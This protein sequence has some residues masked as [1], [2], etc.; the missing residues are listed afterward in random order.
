[1]KILILTSSYNMQL[2]FR[3]EFMEHLLEKNHQLDIYS[4][5]LVEHEI[6]PSKKHNLH[7]FSS[8][9]VCVLVDFLKIFKLIKLDHKIVFNYTVRN[10]FIS[11][12]LATLKLNKKK[13]IYFIAGLGRS[14]NQNSILSKFIVRIVAYA[15]GLND[16]RLV[17]MNNRDNEIFKDYCANPIK[18][19]SEGLNLN[20]FKFIKRIET[21]EK[22]RIVFLGRV[23]E[24]KG[25][26]DILKLAA[27]FSIYPNV[28]IDV[29]GDISETPMDFLDGVKTLANL[30]V[31]GFTKDPLSELINSDLVILPSR[32]NEGLPRIMLESFAIGR[33]CVAYNVP[34][35][36]DIYG[37]TDY[38][39]DF[40][41]DSCEELIQ[42][43]EKVYL[44]NEDS[45]NKTC[46]NLNHSVIMN[47]DLNVINKDLINLLKF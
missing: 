28:R 10:C 19:N 23:I 36:S 8:N 34:G 16:S 17:V 15:S 32:L 14:F 44:S 9:L 43:C 29:F 25:I 11:A 39:T 31:H 41:A 38:Q 33:I 13:N 45:Y 4:D 2:N 46:L 21:Q 40:L 42:I 37:Y 30:K 22:F 12:C 27:S 6:F 1:M 20:H 24:E 5:K 35:C 18:I 26:Y 3:R 7:S 47:H